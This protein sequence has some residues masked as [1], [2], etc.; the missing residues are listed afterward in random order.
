VVV[1]RELFVT[2]KVLIVNCHCFEM[3]TFT[4]LHTTPTNT[5]Y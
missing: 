5:C 1:V 2:L 3:T 4:I